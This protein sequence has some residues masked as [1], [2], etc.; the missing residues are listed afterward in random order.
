MSFHQR[1]VSGIPS[2][3]FTLFILFSYYF[4]IFF[5][6]E[7]SL[8]FAQTLILGRSCLEFKLGTQR[9]SDNFGG[10]IAPSGRPFAPEFQLSYEGTD[11]SLPAV[12]AFSNLD[13]CSQGP[14]STPSTVPLI[15]PCDVSFKTADNLSSSGSNM[16]I[17]DVDAWP[18]ELVSMAIVDTGLTGNGLFFLG[19]MSHS[20]EVNSCFLPCETSVARVDSALITFRHP[21]N[22]RNFRRGVAFSYFIGIMYR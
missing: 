9:F 15:S 8:K 2:V 14:P 5:F 1:L 12:L 19:S 7:F 16:T 21:L 6:C 20:G 18:E 3:F 13:I 4:F 22:C 11:F 10:C 17:C